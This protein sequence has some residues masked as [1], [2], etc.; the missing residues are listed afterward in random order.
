MPVKY[1]KEL[2]IR[3]FESESTGCWMTFLSIKK[4]RVSNLPILPFPA[5]NG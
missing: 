3:F 1:L 4:S 5:M 2:L